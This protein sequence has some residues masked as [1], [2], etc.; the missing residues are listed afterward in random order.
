MTTDG[1]NRLLLTPLPSTGSGVWSGLGI[2][3]FRIRSGFQAKPSC[4]AMVLFLY[5]KGAPRVSWRSGAQRLQ[6]HWKYGDYAFIEKT[7]D[8]AD[9]L[10]DGDHEGLAIDIPSQEMNGWM[11]HSAFAQLPPCT[12]LPSH[13]YG[14][15]PHLLN[16]ALSI[17]EEIQRGCPC[18]KIFAESI[19]LALISHFYGNHG[20]EQSERRRKRQGIAPDKMK[21]VEAYIRANLGNDIS[22]VD[23]AAL[24]QVSLGQFCRTF[25][26]ATGMPPHRYLM[27]ARIDKSK[28]M[29]K[30]SYRSITD[31]ALELGFASA[32]HFSFTFRKFTGVSPREFVRSP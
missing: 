21:M 1:A 18:G 14:A 17:K 30:S 32:S 11:Q 5:L 10:V 23:L 28:T 8:I 7:P 22:L 29:L 25:S 2:Q 31:V 12:S 3:S 19:S 6:R 27:H 24:T 16:L 15:D 4:P 26:L 20:K 9:V 13:A